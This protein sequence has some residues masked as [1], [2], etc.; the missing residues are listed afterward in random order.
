MPYLFWMVLPFALWDT[1]ACPPSEQDEA[2][3]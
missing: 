1:F 2:E 3:S